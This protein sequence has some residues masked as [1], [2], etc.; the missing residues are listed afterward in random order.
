MWLRN[1]ATIKSK[2]PLIY[3][4]KTRSS[5]TFDAWI[6]FTKPS[7]SF[8]KHNHSYRER[9]ELEGWEVGGRKKKNKKRLFSVV[10]GACVIITET[11][12]FKG[13]KSRER[14]QSWTPIKRPGERSIGLR[15]NR[16][17]RLFCIYSEHLKRQSPLSTRA[18]SS[19]SIHYV[20]KGLWMFD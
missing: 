13:S 10:K 15:E 19:L 14:A 9:W 20:S 17:K 1:W 8:R 18:V 5:I 12:R 11:S 16:L 2:C 4:D 6:A 3:E 7:K